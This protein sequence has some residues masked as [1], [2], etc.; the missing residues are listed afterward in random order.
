PAGM[1]VLSASGPAPH[2]ID[3]GGVVFEPL[4]SLEPRDEQVFR[5]QVQ[6]DQ[7]GDQRITVEVKT[8]DL[9]QP[10]RKEEATRVFG[11]D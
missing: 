5:V 2:T 7:A 10:I 9:S 4:D 3:G 11:N 8:D 1:R 6:A